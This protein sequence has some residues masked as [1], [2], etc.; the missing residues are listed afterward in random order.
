MRIQLLS[1]IHTEFHADGGK[2]FI[3][4]LD[5]SGVDVLVLAGDIATEH[6]LEPVLQQFKELYPEVVFV[7]GNHEYYNSSKERIDTILSRA[8]A[9]GVHVLENSSVTING[10]RFIGCTMWFESRPDNFR[11]EHGMNDF[12]VIS[13]FRSWVYGANKDSIHFLKNSVREGDVVVTHHLPSYACVDPKYQGSQLNRFFACEMRSL[14]ELKQP[15]CWLFGHTH[16]SVNLEIGNTKLL[17]NPFGYVGREENP[18]FSDKF[19][20]TV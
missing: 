16:E 19:I 15:A 20:I 12:H 5:P 11:Y 6:T 4:S 7:C 1:D 14:I 8:Q 9:A 10:K 3:Q 13:N 2:T 17:C 18:N